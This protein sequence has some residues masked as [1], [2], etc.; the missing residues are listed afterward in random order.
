VPWK[1]VFRCTGFATAWSKC[2]FTKETID[3]LE[4]KIPDSTK[5]E[6]LKNFKFTMVLPPPR[7]KSLLR[8]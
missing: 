6:Y 4:W 8:S 1:G 7:A 3:R 2:T 5:N